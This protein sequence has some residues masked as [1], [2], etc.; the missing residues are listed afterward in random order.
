MQRRSTRS[1][2]EVL[3]LLQRHPS[4]M[5]G[6]MVEAE[7]DGY[8]RA[9]IYRILNRFCADGI[10]HRI[11]GLDGKQYYAICADCDAAQH[12]HDHLHFQCT[13]CEKVECLPEIPTIRLPEG[14][15]M[16]TFNGLVAG[17]CG[18]CAIS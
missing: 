12:R 4:A 13:R 10:V 15:R 9:T 14:Y 5:S 11:V 3:D 6:D 7:I 8:N 16:E 18:G 2:Q 1:K 17:V